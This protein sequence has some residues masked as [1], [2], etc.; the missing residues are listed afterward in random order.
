MRSCR[1]FRMVLDREHRMLHMSDAFDR[2]VVQCGVRDFKTGAFERSSI[3]GEA[4]ILCSDLDPTR[5][6][7]HDWL[8]ASPVTEFHLEGLRAASEADELMAE[9]YAE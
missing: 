6:M 9:A 7:I 4:V 8:I 1:C 5:C 2:P 3:D